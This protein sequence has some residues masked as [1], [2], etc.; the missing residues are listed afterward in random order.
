MFSGPEQ[1]YSYP[2]LLSMPW[3]ELERPAGKRGFYFAAQDEVARYKVVHLE[4]LPGVSGLRSEG[5]WPR[6]EES[7]G[8][9]VGMKISL[10]HM[11]YQPG[12]SQ[13]DASPV[14]IAAHD[15]GW[16]SAAGIYGRWF[17][18]KFPPPI[19]QP[20]MTT[21]PAFQQC[22]RVAFKELPALAHAVAT[23]GVG[24]LLLG[25]WKT[26]GHADGIPRFVPDPALGSREE[27]TEAIRRCHELG[28]KVTLLVNLQPVSRKHAWY[29]SEL[30]RFACEDRWGVV[31]TEMG[32]GSVATLCDAFTSGERRVWLGTSAPDMRRILVG[33][34]EEL[35]RYG[36]D[37]ICL[38]NFFGRPMDFNPQTAKTPDRGSR[39][40]GIE[41]LQQ[42]IDACSPIRPGFSVSTDLAWDR[43]MT[44]TPAPFLEV[45]SES[46]FRV[47]LPCCRP[48][49]VVAGPDDFRS[50]NEALLAG[51]R[52]CLTGDPLTLGGPEMRAVATYIKAVSE[53]CQAL[54]QTLLEGQPSAAADLKLRGSVRHTVFGNPQSRLHSFVFVNDTGNP[55]D[56][57]LSFAGVSS[58]RPLVVWQPAVGPVKCTLPARLTIP[59]DQCAI[60]TEEAV[61][62]RLG[63]ITPWAPPGGSRRQRVVVE[64]RSPGDLLGLQSSRR[65]IQYLLHAAA[66]SQLH[67]QFAWQCRRTGDRCRHLA[68]GGHRSG[69]RSLGNRLP[70]RP[71]R[72]HGPRAES[73]LAGDRR[74]HGPHL[75][76]SACTGNTRP[77]DQNGGLERLPRKDRAIP[78]DRREHRGLVRLDRAAQ[79]YACRVETVSGLKQTWH[80]SLVGT[81]PFGSPTE[82]AR[83]SGPR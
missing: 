60:V 7:R 46:P 36:V 15:G 54:R 44:L 45:P 20:W 21:T 78:T 19:R 33:Q 72:I 69:I 41:C 47:A 43:L 25:D 80:I 77:H 64:F 58:P 53:V 73:R 22:R 76:R 1:Y 42:V 32:W 39:E 74:C 3:V 23:Y 52:I 26:G 8:L 34:I 48:V 67:A 37:G 56:V 62:E 66:I 31:A 4:M 24:E 17:A 18:A 30:H 27:F 70:R 29:Q 13:F 71:K 6:P 81:P 61:F 14:V 9:P 49:S 51:G 5:N 28:V 82:L 59:G 40:G 38:P 50:V 11:P 83:S 16:Q 68:A 10:V 65:G 55:E 79:D 12:R 63:K 35:A 75:A 57:E 2:N